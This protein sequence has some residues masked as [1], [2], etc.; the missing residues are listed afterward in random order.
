MM[1]EEHTEE[2][3]LVPSL[4]NLYEVSNCGRLRSKRRWKTTGVVFKGYIDKCGYQRACISILNNRSNVAVHRLVAEVFNPNWKPD[5]VVDHIDGNRLNNIP[6]N[7]RMLTHRD[8]IRAYNK[9]RAASTSRFR[10]VS[11]YGPSGKWTARIKALDRNIYI[12]RFSDEVDAARAY[13]SKAIELGYKH[14]ALN[15]FHD[16]IQP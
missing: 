13:N 8:N 14:Q 5:L 10:G 7:L 16:Q 9:Q 6:Q 12:G 11:W 3:R 2:W 15:V 4:K 1:N